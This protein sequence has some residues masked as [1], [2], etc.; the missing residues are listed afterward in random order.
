MQ[1]GRLVLSILMASVAAAWQVGCG[2]P[3]TPSEAASAEQAAR[4]SLPNVVVTRPVRKPLILST[5]QPARIEAYEETPLYAKVAGYVD[6]VAVDIGDVVKKGDPLITLHVPELQ[7]V[8]EQR[9]ALLAQAKAEISQAEAAELAA[10]AAADTT[11]ARVKEVKAGVARTAADTQRWE[12][13][14]L[15]ITSLAESGSVTPKLAEETKNQLR[16]AEAARDEATAAVESAEAAVRQA[17][18]MI[19]KSEAD[20]QAA[21]ARATVAEA[22][23]A[24]AK[25]ML[26]Y[27]ELRAP[28]DGVVISRA[29]D[30]G[31]FVQP[32]G[33]AGAKPLA[34]VARTDRMRVSIDIP[35]MEARFVDVG[36]PVV[37]R[38]QANRGAEIQG[39]IARISWSLDAGNRSLRAEVDV[40]NDDATL[41]P[42][43][44]ATAVIELDRRAEPL[45]LPATAIVANGGQPTCM[46]VEEGQAQRRPVETGLRVGPDVEIVSGV[47]E[48]SEVIAV[49]PEGVAEGQAVE[50]LPPPASK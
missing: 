29:V 45:T 47:S 3:S 44:Y 23:L 48:A 27:T 38:V 7:N 50:P 9:Q 4:A 2:K 37:L 25:T 18:A 39:E 31:H 8:V 33:G 35:E 30:P 43:M 15:R 22:N 11:A 49:R 24:E 13:E 10:R 5:T 16:A 34:A 42:G 28:F 6:N 40:P 46:V 36:D 19:V 21:E 14:H 41:R 26:G 12:A 17:E 32:P 1:R 20:R